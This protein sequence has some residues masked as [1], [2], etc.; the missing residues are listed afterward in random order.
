MGSRQG[1]QIMAYM[2]LN[3]RNT[4]DRDGIALLFLSYTKG[5]KYI[6]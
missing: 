3:V 1:M 2:E 5:T 6:G 4:R